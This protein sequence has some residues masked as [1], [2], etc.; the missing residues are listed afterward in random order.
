MR[1]PT[2]ALAIA[3]SA[4]LL[5]LASAAHAHVTW[6]TGAIEPSLVEARQ[7]R[8]LVLV[9]FWASW[10]GPCQTMD[11]L[12]WSRA[13]VAAAVQR[14]YVP[15]RADADTPEGTALRNRYHIGALPTV[16]A[17]RPDGSEVDRLV[18]DTDSATV[19]A[20]MA[21]WRRGES[22]LSVLAARVAQRPNDLALRLDVGMRYA[23][24]GDEANARLHLERV[25]A[26]DPQNARGFAA[27]ALYALGDRLYLR[28][29]RDAAHAIP[30]LEA[31]VTRFPTT[32]SA[33]SAQVPLA[34]ALHRVGRDVAARAVV[35]AFLR[36]ATGMEAAHR[37]NNVAWM[38]FREHW[39]LPR[40]EQIARAG[41][42]QS[43]R[44]HALI[45][46]LAHVVFAQGR[47]VE[48]VQLEQQAAQLDPSNQFY[49]DTIEEF[50]RG[51]PASPP[52]ASPAPASTRARPS[53]GPT[54][55]LRHVRGSTP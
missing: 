1:P 49:R 30:H 45:D 10:C 20:A 39:D 18:G 44:D 52:T 53:P 12:V 37:A 27:R 47:A 51:V 25:V 43:P 28:A 13:E 34:T 38:M 35:D 23:D 8:Q 36:G 40:A 3:L 2:R 15:L 22:T 21:A 19:L 16:L 24:R 26:D 54:R 50:R 41:L 42:A 17:L 33:V 31:L 9:D 4:A 55:R 11:A 14:D 48:A 29:R 5:L 32:E 46:A 7:R 6:R